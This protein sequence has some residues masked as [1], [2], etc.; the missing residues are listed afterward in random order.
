M[1]STKHE[2]EPRLQSSRFGNEFTSDRVI[3]VMALE[4][5]GDAV[6]KSYK[7]TSSSLI[8]WP[9]RLHLVT[10]GGIPRVSYSCRHHDRDPSLP[11][12]VSP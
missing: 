1:K 10:S 4:T 6:Y 11:A 2:A 12:A 9:S 5:Q 3:E 7:C 8:F